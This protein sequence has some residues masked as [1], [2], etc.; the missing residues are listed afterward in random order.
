[1]LLHGLDK[2]QGKDTWQ[3]SSYTGQFKTP[4]DDN[5]YIYRGLLSYFFFVVSFIPNFHT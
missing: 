1:M 3:Y 4:Q 2:I 5:R